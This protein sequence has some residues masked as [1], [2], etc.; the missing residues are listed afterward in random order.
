M[1]LLQIVHTENL[2]GYTPLILLLFGMSGI[3]LH[4]LVKLNKLNKKTKGEIKLSEYWKYERFS[5]AIAIIMVVLAVISSQEIVSL[6][7]AGNW[8]S[9]AFIFIGYAGQSLLVSLI[10]RA[11]NAVSKKDE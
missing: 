9:G 2:I 1:K 11:E 5:V 4:N 6:K 10:G 8:I 7:L 3:L